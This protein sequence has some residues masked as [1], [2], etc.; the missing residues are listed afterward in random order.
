[1]AALEEVLQQPKHPAAKMHE[2]LVALRRKDLD[3]ISERIFSPGCLVECLVLGN[4][5]H[6]EAHSLISG[7]LTPFQNS[8]SSSRDTKASG[9]ATAVGVCSSHSADQVPARIELVLPHV[10]SLSILSLGGTNADD[11]NSCV[12][13]SLCNIARA[14]PENEALAA[15]LMRV[16]K[17][18]F[19]NDLRTRQQLGY[20]VSSFVRTRAVFVSLVFLVQ[21]E[22]APEIARRSISVFLEQGFNH[23]LHQLSEQEF[24]QHCESVVHQL[25]EEPRN[26]W[27]SLQRD[28]LPIE[29]RTFTFNVRQ[30]QVA[31]LLN[32]R[33]NDLRGFV[34][35]HVQKAP[36]LAVL[37]RSPSCP[38]I[39]PIGEERRARSLTKWSLDFF[40]QELEQVQS[41]VTFGKKMSGETRPLSVAGMALGAV[42]PKGVSS[43]TAVSQPAAA[44]PLTSAA[45]A[46]QTTTPA[47]EMSG[48][49]HGSKT[50]GAGAGSVITAVKDVAFDECERGA[51]NGS[52]AVVASKGDDA[53]NTRN[54]DIAVETDADA[55]AAGPD[56]LGP[57]P[58]DVAQIP[59]AGESDDEEEC[60]VQ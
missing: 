1:M 42:E 34:R 18:M 24:K 17:P 15:V 46:K 6:S 39:T 31:L 29:E 11:K 43:T 30:R 10:P 56:T 50:S 25:E 60:R 32:L 59:Q 57:A 58:S 13:E 53:G 19:F 55:D 8:I 36:Q 22:R 28:W 51:G 33:L 48:F 52:A 4:L 5:D 20:V 21:T 14:T 38:N 40:K 7:A 49:G 41:N 9:C 27:E 54:A 45:A 2:A 23:I 26:L 12:V 35:E 47:H 16:L 3:G 37:V 44:S